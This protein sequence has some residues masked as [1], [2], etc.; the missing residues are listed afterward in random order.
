MATEVM[1]A[2]ITV[3][4]SVL[5][6][7]VSYFLTKRQQR[8]AE[9]R[10]SKL[11]HYKVLLSSISDLAVDN[12][13]VEAHQKFALAMNTLALVA[14]QKVIKAMLAFHDGVKL[15]SE[16]RSLERH[17]QLLADLLLAIREDLGMKPKDDP[18]TFRYHLVGAPP[19]RK[20]H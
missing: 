1:V 14:P 6:A 12:Q 10:D 15:S 9:W 7:A 16:D 13:D 18:A 3:S 11:N 20:K 17:D 5:V 2:V 8:E 19:R 4:G